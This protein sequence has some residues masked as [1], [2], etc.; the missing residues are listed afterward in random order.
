MPLLF[1][2]G[3]FGALVLTATP[4]TTLPQA[5]RDLFAGFGRPAGTVPVDEADLPTE[6]DPRAVAPASSADVR[7]ADARDL[8]EAETSTLPTDEELEQ[9]AEAVEDDERR[10]GRA[11]VRRPRKPRVAKPEP[12]AARRSPARPSS[13]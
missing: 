2:L 5:I 13:S 3:A 9:Y 12:R 1:L 6:L 7:L 4:L 10:D 8:A 11:R